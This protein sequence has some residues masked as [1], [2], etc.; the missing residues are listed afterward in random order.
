SR[1]SDRGVRAS[2]LGANSIPHAGAPTSLGPPPAAFPVPS[3][4]VAARRVNRSAAGSRGKDVGPRETF[5]C[6][7]GRLKRLDT[8]QGS[9]ESGRLV[10]A[11]T[12]SPFTLPPQETLMRFFLPPPTTAY[13]GGID[14]HASTIY[15]VVL[16]R[17]GNVCL[18][19]NLPSRPDA[20][21]NA[22]TPFRPDLVVASACVHSWY[23]LANT[24][25]EHH[26]A[27]VLGHA[28]GRK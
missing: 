10:V 24:C 20:F 14:L 3:R 16:D 7:A 27:F 28:R 18:R 2:A 1:P 5:S 4:G 12:D 21:R 25:A 8:H 19:R 17:D 11:G 13:Y 9:P 15:L 26:L 22:S 6:V 23:W